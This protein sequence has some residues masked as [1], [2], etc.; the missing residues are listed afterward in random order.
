MSV[1]V[2]LRILHRFIGF[3]V[4]TAVATKTEQVS[5]ENIWAEEG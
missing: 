4:L 5:E 2:Y 3:E 1:G